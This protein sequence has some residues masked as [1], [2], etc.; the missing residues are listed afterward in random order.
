[1]TLNPK[2]AELEAAI[3]GIA[4]NLFG[5]TPR[6]RKCPSEVNYCVLLSFDD[7]TA[8]RVVKMANRNPWAVE[9]ER[10]LYP[11][12]R[13]TGLPVPEIE[14]THEDC[15]ESTEP[16]IVM[17]KFSDYTLG[18]LC[19]TNHDAAMSAVEASGRF[20]QN[21]HRRFGEK[22][23]Y[24]LAMDDLRGQLGA[25]Q[26]QLDQEQDLGL[27]KES[28]P[29][30]SR[31]VEQHLSTLSNPSIKRLTHGQPHTRNIL[32]DET[33]RICVIDFGETIG[34]SS[35][36]RDLYT[37]LNSHDGWSSGTG[38]P[39]Q[40]A[41]I[42]EGYGAIDEADIQELHYWE[43]SFWVKALI[44]YMRFAE[45]PANDSQFVAEQLR[46]IQSTIREIATGRGI[47]HS[48]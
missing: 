17:P 9:V 47:I 29:E 26:Q 42:L 44:D 4:R 32:A 45:D 41:A 30:L 2:S 24:Y 22:F 3:L 34:M 15:P 28:E 25:I 6:L 33:G 19:E 21:V 43:F 36:L 40:R 35:P 8:D 23:T 48:L 46:K 20:I 10:Q 7:P 5:K 31:I 12:M 38:D 16:F 13:A 27:I 37:L 18:E 39:A 11:A 14:F 1:M